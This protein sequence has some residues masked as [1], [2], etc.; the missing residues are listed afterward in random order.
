MEATLMSG[1]EHSTEDKSFDPIMEMI[2]ADLSV[3]SANVHLN[4]AV[5]PKVD[6]QMGILH[7]KLGFGFGVRLDVVRF[8][9]Q[10]SDFKSR[11][12]LP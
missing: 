12:A 4:V 1:E 8:D 3:E 11:A 2:P 7:T 5:G 9:S 6:I 10:F